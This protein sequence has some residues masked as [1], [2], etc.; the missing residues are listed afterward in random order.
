[1]PEFLQQSL[2]D[3]STMDIMATPHPSGSRNASSLHTELEIRY[4]TA[5]PISEA[6]T[7]TTSHGEHMWLVSVCVATT[8]SCVDIDTMLMLT[9]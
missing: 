4:S 7:E 2:E 5:N 9:L 3:L 6:I 8:E 1:M